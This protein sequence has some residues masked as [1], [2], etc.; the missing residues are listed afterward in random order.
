MDAKQSRRDERQSTEVTTDSSAPARR[1]RLT[2]VREQELYGAVIDLVREV[3][4][5]ALTMDAVAVRTR[6]SKAT[7]YRR[8]RS[9]QKLVATALKS[10]T[11]VHVENID[12]GSLT[13]DLHE[14]ADRIGDGSA[15]DVPLIR[16]L[17]RASAIN[18]DLAE[19]M[20]RH[21]IEPELTGVRQMLGRAANREEIRADVPAAD[22]LLHMM[23]GSVVTRCLLEDVEVDAAFIHRYIDA[24]VLS[25]LGIG[26]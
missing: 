23:L 10:T 22:L 15:V 17:A 8:W 6:C 14:F 1:T 2:P 19:A 21:M 25:A 13:G 12:T 20:R 3:G 16:G 4:F 11:A 5:D 24:V 7:L 9:K 26:R 18:P